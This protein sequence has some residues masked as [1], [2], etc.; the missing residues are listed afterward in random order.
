MQIVTECHCEFIID[1][2]RLLVEP[3]IHRKRP[4]EKKKKAP[5]EKMH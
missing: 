1:I 2:D 4:K 3:N 5:G